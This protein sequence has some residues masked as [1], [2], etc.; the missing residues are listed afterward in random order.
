MGTELPPASRIA[1][2]EVLTIRR[3]QI[4]AAPAAVGASLDPAEDVEETLRVVMVRLWP[5][6]RN[7]T[8]TA[9]ER[10]S[11][12]THLSR[13][14][15]AASSDDLRFL[16]AWNCAYEALPGTAWTSH[17]RRELVEPFLAAYGSL[18]DHHLTRL[19]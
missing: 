9:E 8:A 7:G 2:A 15:Q 11:F 16:D 19:V 13:L 10:A 5:R 17:E 6:V 12:F 3:R 4:E 18:L 14:R 1:L